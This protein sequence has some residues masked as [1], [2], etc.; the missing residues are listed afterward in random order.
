MRIAGVPDEHLEQIH[1][2]YG[3]G[4]GGELGYKHLPS[5]IMVRRM[6]P[7]TGS[8]LKFRNQLLAELREQLIAAGIVSPQQ[9]EDH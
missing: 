6:C 4:K 9:T 2:W 3:P 1:L 8:L 7:P 5:G